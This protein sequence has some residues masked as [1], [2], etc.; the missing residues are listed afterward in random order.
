MEDKRD[1][2]LQVAVREFAEHGYKAASTNQ[3]CDAA[4]VSKGL[5][6]H[7][8]GS[9]EKL[10]TAAVTYSMDLA[11]RE[12]S[13]EEMPKGDFV[14]GAIWSTKQKLSFSRKYPA[15]FQLIMQSYA[16]P[17]AVLAE[18]LRAYYAELMQ[19]Q[20]VYVNQVFEKVTLREDVSYEDA[21]DVVQGLFDYTIKM[22]TDYMQRHP[23]ATMEDMQPLADKFK[24]MMAIVERGMVDKA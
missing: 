3:I 12:V 20:E 24:N 7:Y 6:F 1:K 23:N 17:P 4:G 9:K 22:A 14:Q 2:I 21:R 16:N 18:R 15:V 5:I 8:F 19:V 11:M 10:Y 13:M